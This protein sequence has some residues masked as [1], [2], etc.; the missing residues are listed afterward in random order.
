MAATDG[1][2]F[3]GTFNHAGTGLFKNNTAGDIGA[4]DV[5]TL[6]TAVKES[7]VNRIDDAYT[8]PFPQVTAAGT[9]TYTATLSPAISAYAAGQKFQILFTNANTG[10]ATLNL[11]TVGALAITKNGA[12]ALA[13]GDIP[14]GSIKILAYDGTQLQ[15]LGDGVGTL[16]NAAVALT[17]AASIDLTAIK[18]TLTTASSRTFTISYTGD[19]ISIEVTLSATTATQTFPAGSLCVSE[20]VATGDNTC[21]MAGVSGDKYMFAIKKIG[22]VYYVVAKNFGQ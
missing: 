14:A 13:A 4:D 6:V 15:I 20:G 18:H 2:T 3:E 1:L 5:R 21:P 9:D 10:A 8:A 17:D 19:D 7:Y 22:S 11:N 16:V 12:T